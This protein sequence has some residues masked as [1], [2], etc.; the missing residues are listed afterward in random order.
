MNAEAALRAAPLYTDEV[1]YVVLKLPPRAITIA[2]G[3]VAEI[4]DPFGA[5]LVDKAEVT[6]VLPAEMADEFATRLRDAE[7]TAPYRLI[8]FDLALPPDLT[9]FMALVAGLLAD[10]Q[11][12]IIPLGAYSYDHILVPAGDFARAWQTIEEWQRT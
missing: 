6:L 9:G 4:G 11:I 7:R 2:A 5:L 8:S 1:E 3:V 10:A 12:S